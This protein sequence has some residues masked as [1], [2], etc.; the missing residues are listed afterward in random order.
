MGVK[1]M[2][3]GPEHAAKGFSLANWIDL[4]KKYIITI[5][6]AAK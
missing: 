1:Y 5:K 6:L 3:R 2:T 4:E